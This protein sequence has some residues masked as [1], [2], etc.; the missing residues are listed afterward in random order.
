MDRSSLSELPSSFGGLSGLNF[1]G[2]SGLSSNPFLQVDPSLV[3]GAQPPLLSSG[4]FIYPEG[5][6]KPSRGRFELAF[7]QIGCSVG[8]GAGIGGAVGTFKGTNQNLKNTL[9]PDHFLTIFLPTF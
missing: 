9:N 7:G 3:S 4:E 1:G 5:A 2:S 6:A 8:V